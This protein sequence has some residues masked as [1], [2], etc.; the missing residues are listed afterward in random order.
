M[1]AGTSLRNLFFCFIAAM[2][3]GLAFVAQA[4]GNVMGPLTFTCLRCFLG[5]LALFPFI[6][7]YYGELRIDPET[8]KAGCISGILLTGGI[9]LQQIGLLHTAPGKAGFISTLYIILVPVISLLSGKNVKKTVFA[10]M[11]MG[12]CGLYLLCVPPGE[13]ITDINRWD[14]YVLVSSLV[15]TCQIMTVDHFA[16]KVQGIKMSLVQ[17]I[18]C[19]TLSGIMMLIFEAPDAAAV[20]SG[21]IP[22]LFAGLCSTG[23]AYTLQIIGQRNVNPS[24]ASLVFSFESVFS[25]LGSWL[26][27]GERLSL[28]ETIGCGIMF[29]AVLVAQVL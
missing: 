25:V 28:R 13:S 16:G 8:A 15:F 10:A 23:I 14:I 26:I 6:W 2:I 17:F 24:L 7:F 9:N 18:V 11:V 27:L 22:L 20:R 4:E 12:L 1:R 29:A 21:L 19:G 5:C 3:W